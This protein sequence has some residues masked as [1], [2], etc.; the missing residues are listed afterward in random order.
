[1]CRRGLTLRVDV[2]FPTVSLP[3]AVALWSGLTQQQTGIMNRFNRPLAPPLDRRGIPAQVPG[4]IAITEGVMVEKPDGTTKPGNYGWIARSL[5]FAHTEPPAHKESPVRDA[6][7]EAWARAWEGRA[8]AAVAGE[9]PLVLVHLM[10]VDVAGH[11]DGLGGAYPKV[12]AEADVILGGL[13]AAGLGAGAAWW[14]IPRLPPAWRPVP[15]QGPAI[16]TAALAEMQ[17]AVDDG[18]D[19]GR[20]ADDWL[21]AHPLRD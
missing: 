10:R 16:D 8:R 14:A 4:S 15:A 3:V 11:K 1:M 5:G 12:A 6:D 17:Q 18:A 9:A 19:P 21:S 2:G 13:V 7:G 20:V